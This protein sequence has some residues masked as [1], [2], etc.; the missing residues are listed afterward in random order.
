MSYTSRDQ[1]L[2][3]DWLMFYNAES[4][5]SIDYVADLAGAF[6]KARAEGYAE[7]YR[8]ALAGKDLGGSPVKP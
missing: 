7:G 4:G 8:D 2:A 6:A 1:S 3:E 5:G